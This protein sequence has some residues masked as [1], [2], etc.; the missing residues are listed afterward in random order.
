MLVTMLAGTA[1]VM[2]VGARH[3][4]PYSPAPLPTR[5][6]EQPWLSREAAA[7]LVGTNG[8]L[9]PLFADVRL[10][11]PAPSPAVRER[12]ATFARDNRVAIDLEVEGDELAAVRLDLSYSGGVGYEGA[13]VFAL[14]LGRP[15]TGG[16]GPD[17]WINDWYIASEDG[18]YMRARV[19]VNRVTVRW[20]KASTLPDLLDRAESLLGSTVD[21]VRDAAR[22]RWTE[23]EPNHRYLIQVPYPLRSN[24]FDYAVQLS[25][26][27]APGIQVV[28]E[29]GRVAEVSLMLRDLDDDDTSKLLRATL[30]SRWGR[31][32]VIREDTWSWRTS[33]RA[34]TAEVSDYMPSITIRRRS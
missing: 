5:P 6:P 16:C 29:R 10:G 22:D 24:L 32:R 1:F 8:R 4:G 20:E 31:P 11:G 13:D 3:A 19:R 9:G 26:H 21:A 27:D 30:R 12:I 14:R 33:D 23:L 25:P 18:V 7:Q 15:S 34:V 28:I 2:L 17:T